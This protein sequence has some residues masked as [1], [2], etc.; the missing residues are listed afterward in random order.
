M[1]TPQKQYLNSRVVKT[2][3]GFLLSAISGTYQDSRMEI[4]S[5]VK[6]DDDLIVNAIHGTLRLTRSKEGILVQAQLTINVDNECSRCAD[7]VVQD[8]DIEIEELFAN[9]DTTISEF[10]V[11]ADANLDLAP[12][13]RAETLIAMSQRILCRDDCKGLCATC[14]ANRNYE[15]CNCDQDVI[16]PRFAAL[17]NLLAR[18]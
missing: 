2:N 9:A 18:D 16:D 6:L 15:T 13:L 1:K 17:K 12:L 3:V 4:P 11:G 5:P 14:G 8:V 10:S 7:T